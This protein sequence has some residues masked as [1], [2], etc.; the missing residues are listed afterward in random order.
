MDGIWAVFVCARRVQLDEPRLK[1]WVAG[2]KEPLTQAFA[3]GYSPCTFQARR[4]CL[5]VVTGHER[6]LTCVKWIPRNGKKPLV[7]S[8]P[9]DCGT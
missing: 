3:L 4:V 9:G 2:M 1:A 8:P 7:E 6:K 5:R